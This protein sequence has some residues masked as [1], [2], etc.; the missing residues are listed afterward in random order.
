MIGR[1]FTGTER[2]TTAAEALL[3]CQALRLRSPSTKV[4]SPGWASVSERAFAMGRSASP[5]TSPRTH[6]ASCRTVTLTMR[7]FSSLRAADARILR[8][9]TGQRKV[10]KRRSPNKCNRCRSFPDGAF[11]GNIGSFCDSGQRE[12]SGDVRKRSGPADYDGTRPVSR[13]NSAADCG[14]P[15]VSIVPELAT[16]QAQ[17][18]PFQAFLSPSSA[19]PQTMQEMRMDPRRSVTM[20]LA[21]PTRSSCQVASGV[22]SG[23]AGKLSIIRREASK[24]SSMRLVRIASQLGTLPAAK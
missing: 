6:S 7:P 5:R 10:P 12:V 23:K 15:S 14:P 13:A 17:L 9:F 21:K 18:N 11:R 16:A 2:G 19:F 20:P 22:S 1:P 4:M 3:L 8:G 24:P